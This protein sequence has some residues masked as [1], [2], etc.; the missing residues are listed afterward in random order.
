MRVL[1]VLIMVLF[2]YGIATTVRW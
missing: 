2:H 1:K